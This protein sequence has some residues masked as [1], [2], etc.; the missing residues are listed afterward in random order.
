MQQLLPLWSPL[1]PL[2]ILSHLKSHHKYSVFVRLICN[3]LPSKACFHSSNFLLASFLVSVTKTMS[4]VRSIHYG[5]VSQMDLEISVILIVKMR[6][7]RTDSW[8]SPLAWERLCNT[9]RCLNVSRNSVIHVLYY[10]NVPLW[11]T[12]ILE[13]I[14]NDASWYTIILFL[15]VNEH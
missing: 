4:S 12:T 7:F 11:N 3:S 10:L 2:S 15:Q 13:T 9:H 14:P 5:M 6:R 8:C 1:A